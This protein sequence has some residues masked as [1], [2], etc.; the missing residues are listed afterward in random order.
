ML[1]AMDVKPYQAVAMLAL[2]SALCS[3]QALG[4]WQLV[5]D[6]SQLSYTTTKVFPGAEKSAAENNRFANLEGEVGD[7][8]GAEVRVL[9]DSVNTNVAIRD[10]RMRKI[11]FRTEE[12][13]VAKVSTKVPSTVLGEPGLHQIDLTL[14]LELHGITKAMTVPV[15][16]VNEGDRLLVASMSPVLVDAADFGFAGGVAELTKLAGLM[17]IPTT[18]PVSFN[19]V[20]QNQ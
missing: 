6:Q 11:V 13:P 12:F 7:Q 15:T 3:T 19:L 2:L 1:Q 9:L 20:F 14:Q 10:E 18:V 5:S 8:G 4:G 16:V 17:Y